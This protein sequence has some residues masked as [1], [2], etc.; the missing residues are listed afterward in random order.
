MLT[1]KGEAR[2][3]SKKLLDAEPEYEALAVLLGDACRDLAAL[4]IRAAYADL[5]ADAH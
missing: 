2:K 1:G 3:V 4:A 5:L